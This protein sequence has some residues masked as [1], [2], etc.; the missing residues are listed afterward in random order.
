MRSLL[1]VPGSSA[2]MMA[3]AAA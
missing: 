3:K 2:R 1:F